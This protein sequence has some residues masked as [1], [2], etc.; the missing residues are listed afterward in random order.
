MIEEYKLIATTSKDHNGFFL[1]NEYAKITKGDSYDIYQYY[2]I[3]VRED[4]YHD[5][6]YNGIIVHS[7][8]LINYVSNVDYLNGIEKEITETDYINYGKAFREYISK[9]KDSIKTIKDR[10]DLKE[11]KA[12]LVS[13]P[14]NTDELTYIN[15]K[16]NRCTIVIKL[17]SGKFR[18]IRLEIQDKVTLRFI[19]TDYNSEDDCRSF[20]MEYIFPNNIMMTDIIKDKSLVEN[21]KE[22][23]DNYVKNFPIKLKS[24]KL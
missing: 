6:P 24:Y 8:E 13:F 21:I 14:Q 18:L 10:L 12:E 22:L 17:D 7:I 1:S 19:Y 11:I 4:I 3:T 16:E 23:S 20:I 15:L 2:K 9:M 5:P